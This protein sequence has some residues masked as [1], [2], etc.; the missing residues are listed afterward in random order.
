[1]YYLATCDDNGKCFGFLRKDETISKDPDN[2][3]DKLMSFQ[4]K[5]KCHEK[6]LQLNLGRLL[7]PNGRAYR[8]VPVRS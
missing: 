8:V 5:A 6:A 4:M 1:M 2:E 3:I 7:L